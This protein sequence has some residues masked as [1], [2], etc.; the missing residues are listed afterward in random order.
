MSLSLTLSKFYTIFRSFHSW[1]W[2]SKWWP[3]YKALIRYLPNLSFAYFVQTSNKNIVW[4]VVKS[5]KKDI[6]MLLIYDV[7]LV[8]LVGFSGMPL[9]SSYFG[10]NILER[11]GKVPVGVNSSS[12]GG[13]WIVWTPVVQRKN[14]NL[15]KWW[16][17][18]E[19]LQ[20]KRLAVISRKAV[21][22]NTKR[23]LSSLI[24][25]FHVKSC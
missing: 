6:R 15:S 7:L 25:F 11:V 21:S 22:Q 24:K 8:H 16:E 18:T 4:N 2:T 13:W 14:R 1:L 10:G 20:Q 19:T 17:Q 9:W 5:S 12:V 23:V 3:G